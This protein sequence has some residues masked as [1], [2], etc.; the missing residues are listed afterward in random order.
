MVKLTAW[1][2]SEKPPFEESFNPRFRE[3]GDGGVLYGLKVEL[4]LDS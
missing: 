4:N 3:G 1:W 2:A